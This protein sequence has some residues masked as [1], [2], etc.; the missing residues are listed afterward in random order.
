MYVTNKKH[1]LKTTFRGNRKSPPPYEF[2]K[3]IR[4]YALYTRDIFTL[5]CGPTLGGRVTVCLYVR[6]SRAYATH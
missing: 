5:L 3:H 4:G 2:L 6:L 1:E